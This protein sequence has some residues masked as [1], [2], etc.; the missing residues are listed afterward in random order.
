MGLGS[1]FLNLKN[2]LSNSNL[3]LFL[4]AIPTAGNRGRL[5]SDF[6]LAQSAEGASTS[7]QTT[8]GEQRAFIS[9]FFVNQLT[10]AAARPAQYCIRRCA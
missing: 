7:T 6:D 4:R 1:S 2:P 3:A 8:P 10:A 5:Q 9:L